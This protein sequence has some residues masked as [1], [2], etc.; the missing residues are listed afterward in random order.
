MKLAT[1]IETLWVPENSANLMPGEA[2]RGL[3]ERTKLD[4]G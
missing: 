2:Q 3:L 1:P 4:E